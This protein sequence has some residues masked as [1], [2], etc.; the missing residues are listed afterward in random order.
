MKVIFHRGGIKMHLRPIW[1]LGADFWPM[2]VARKVK[3]WNKLKKSNI[4]KPDIMFQMRT[5]WHKPVSDGD[6]FLEIIN[7]YCVNDNT[8]YLNYYV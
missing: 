5:N 4:L 2:F 6:E 8:S 7:I 1:V 3:Q